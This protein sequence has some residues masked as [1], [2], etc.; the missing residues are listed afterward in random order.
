MSKDSGSRG[1][2]VSGY[3]I[4]VG[5]T[6]SEQ[7]V[8]GVIETTDGETVIGYAD[9]TGRAL[10]TYVHDLFKNKEFAACIVNNVARMKGLDHPTESEPFSQEAAFDKLASHLRK[11]L[12]MGRVYEALSPSVEYRISD[13]LYADGVVETPSAFSLSSYCQGRSLLL[14]IL[15][16]CW[17][18]QADARPLGI[19]DEGYSTTRFR[20]IH[21]LQ[22][23]LRAPRLGLLQ[24]GVNIVNLEVGAPVWR[25]VHSS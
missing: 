8:S 15:W 16:L 14:V 21:W 10:G 22:R 19:H 12:D 1:M 23:D 18:H 9:R 4:H 6:E 2:V 11:H 17:R 25:H 5:V 3:E 13:Q 24:R 20:N 7:G